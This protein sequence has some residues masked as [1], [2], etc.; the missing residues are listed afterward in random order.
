M[1][2]DKKAVFLSVLILVLVPSVCGLNLI[3]DHLSPIIFEPGKKIVNHYIISGTDK[4]VKI[5][6]G[7]DLLEYVNITSIVDNQ[8]DLMITVPEI[9][10]ES[11]QYWFSLQATE[12]NDEKSS[13]VGSLLS[14]SLRFV[15]EVPPHG[16]AISISFDVPDINEHQ[17]IPFSV[18][19]VSKGLEDIDLL[20]GTITVYD[21]KNSSVASLLLNVKA[22]PGLSSTS[23]SASLP[24]DK[25]SAGKYWAEAVVNYDGEEKKARDNFKVGN[26]DLILVNYTSQLEQGFGEF[27]AQVENNWGNSIQIAY[28]IVSI[29]GTELLITPA[30]FLGPWQQGELKGILR[31]AFEPGVYNGTIQLFYDDLSKTEDVMFTIF[32]PLKE[33]QETSAATILLTAGIFSLIVIIFIIGFVLIKRKIVK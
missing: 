30:I 19:I 27:H 3:G 5:S 2:D 15:V 17:P 20:K 11:G 9:L 25:L 22:L 28:A 31:T 6:L 1:I 14:V 13:G 21:L 4:E 7:G 16:K 33:A 23:L 18:D 29:N 8:F 24:P 32:E 26:L 10:P 12:I